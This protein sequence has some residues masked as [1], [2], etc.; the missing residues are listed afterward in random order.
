M[1]R[2]ISLPIPVIR[3]LR[4][5]GEDIRDARLRR[6]IATTMMAERASI[7][8]MTLHKLERGDP[9]VSVGTYATVLFILGLNDRLADLAN[10]RHDPTGLQLDEERL[11][12]RIRVRR[13]DRRVAA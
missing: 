3:T 5:L 2:S 4:K 12:R 9:G 11:P 8:R 7:S 6:R 13:A 1:S 10:V